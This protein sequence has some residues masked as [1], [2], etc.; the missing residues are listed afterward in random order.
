MF[1]TY[2]A[3]ISSLASFFFFKE[4]ISIHNALFETTTTDV[5]SYYDLQFLRPS[6]GSLILS[7]SLISEIISRHPTLSVSDMIC[8]VCVFWGL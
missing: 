4:I 5:C 1:P 7:Q 8:H 6:K 3:Y 2:V